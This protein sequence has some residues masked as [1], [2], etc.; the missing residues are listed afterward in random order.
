MHPIFSIDLI[1]VIAS[2]NSEMELLGIELVT[3]V[4]VADLPVTQTDYVSE[5]HD[6]YKY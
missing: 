4:L 5:F 3:S 6:L 2:K 1:Y